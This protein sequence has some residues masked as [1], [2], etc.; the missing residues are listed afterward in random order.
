MDY[1]VCTQKPCSVC[2]RRHLNRVIELSYK[3]VAILLHNNIY[4]CCSQQS[5]CRQSLLIVIHTWFSIE[6]FGN[7]GVWVQWPHM[8]QVLPLDARLANGQS[9]RVSV[10]SR[11][12]QSQFQT[13]RQFRFKVARSGLHYQH[14]E[15]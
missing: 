7:A 5:H 6:Q 14:H 1:G 4:D 3:K 8:H 10:N 12:R 11:G 2:L 13:C 15:E 9:D